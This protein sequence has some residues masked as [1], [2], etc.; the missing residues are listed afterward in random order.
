MAINVHAHLHKDTSVEERVEHYRHD[1][2]SHT[3][4][5]GPWDLVSEAMAKYPDFVVGFGQ[6]RHG[7][8]TTVDTVKQIVD[9]GFRGVKIIGLRRRYDDPELFPMYEAICQAGLPIVFHTGYLAIQSPPIADDGACGS[10]LFMRPGRLDTL[11][12]AFPE[13]VMIGAHL[14]APWCD[15]A[16][17]VMTKHKNVY[18]DMSGGTVKMKSL[19]W[20]RRRFMTGAGGGFLRDEGEELDVKLLE[21]LVFGTDNPAP[22]TMLEFYH[23]FCDKLGLPDA[24][25]YKIMTGNAAKILGLTD[26]VEPAP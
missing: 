13:L 19:S 23:N 4:T 2:V 9:R 17:S 6:I 11:A 21:K 25:R 1:E 26:A 20:F 12:R 8:P 7:T 18:F 10:M 16:C 24:T 22:A 3:V 5:F 14:G 15:E